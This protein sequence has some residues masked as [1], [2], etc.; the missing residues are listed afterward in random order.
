MF[1]NSRSSAKDGTASTNQYFEA[2]ILNKYGGL[3]VATSADFASNDFIEVNVTFE[4][5]ISFKPH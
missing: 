1:T 4:S 5:G 2:N 3:M